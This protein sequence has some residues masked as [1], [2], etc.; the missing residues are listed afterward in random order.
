MLSP[1]VIA[2]G[3]I[4]CLM[5]GLAILLIAYAR[6]RADSDA[7]NVHLQRT[8]ER[9]VSSGVMNDLSSGLGNALQ[10]PS[11]SVSH[12]WVQQGVKLLGMQAWG[13]SKKNAMGLLAAA[14]TLLLVVWVK[15][16]VLLAL[17]TVLVFAFAVVFFFWKRVE[18]KREKMLEQLP[19]FLDNMVR[20]IT[21]GTSPQAAF[22]MSVPNVP[23]PLGTALQQASAVLA[24]SSN[25]GY[26]MEQLEDAWRLPEF[27]L[28]AA[29][30]RMSTK[31]GGRTD[32]VLERVASYI[33][34][35]HSAERELHAMSAEVRLSAWVLSLL[36][37]VVGTLIMVI[38]DGYFLRMWNDA[39][40]RQMILLAAGLELVGVALLYRLA[41]LR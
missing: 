8:I 23:Q 30:F 1:I 33:R 28:L 3:A 29:V 6:Q 22:Q 18:K 31:Y 12:L 10:L 24:A 27:G 36:P 37:L 9:Q 7:L 40:G 17:M 35:K 14:V 39:S 32:L 2:L 25:L 5:L 15:A 41:K 16:G 38:N 4:A 13:V 20:L 26:A 21:I 19:G 34:D 11:K